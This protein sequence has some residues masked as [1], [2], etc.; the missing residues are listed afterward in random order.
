M[1]KGRNTTV[2][3]VRLPD[4]IVTRLKALARSRRRTISE[5]MT[6]TVSD[7]INYSHLYDEKRQ[8]IL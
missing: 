3:G 8:T 4:E 1:S 2:V 7:L 5:L 6:Q